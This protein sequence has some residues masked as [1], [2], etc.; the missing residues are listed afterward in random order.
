MKII[1][2]RSRAIVPSVNKVAK[3]LSKTGH[4]VTLLLWD[5]Q[6]TLKKQSIGYQVSLFTLRAP[7]DNIGV[8]I[9]L[10]IWWIYEFLFLLR[11]EADVIHACDL[12][13]LLPAIFVKLF[14]RTKINYT[15]YDFYA[16]NLVVKTPSA[17]KR[18]VARVEKSAISLVEVLFLVDESRFQ[19]VKEAKIK[20][21][22]YIYNSP[23][24]YL[25][26]M[27]KVIS[28]TGQITLFYAG[29]IH[30]SRGLEYM[31]DAVGEL[32]NVCLIL[33]GDG[34]GSDALKRRIKNKS[35]IQYIG[36]LSYE[37]VMEKSLES[38]IL[39]AFYD[40]RLPSNKY[41]SP[42]KLFEAMMCRKPI[43]VNDGN[44]M[45][46]KVRKINCGLVVPYGDIR[47]IKEAII[48]LMENPELCKRLGENGRE[49]YEKQ[50]SWDIM[51][52]RI[53]EAYKML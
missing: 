27:P 35:N 29:V 48:T 17:F 41:A 51:E 37:S 44:T 5:R 53:V 36:Y 8:L 24:D 26:K 13:T 19:Q 11:S 18:L 30:P 31:I 7:Y 1:L 33:A 21:V 43:I 6:N 9:Y 49:A 28:N 16:D 42:N 3:V 39:F 15:I 14:K 38:D 2:V 40:V 22:V 32:S 46:D 10:P 25:V 34:R 52:S 20:K 45:A 50:Y 4:H 47:A 12:D 23:P